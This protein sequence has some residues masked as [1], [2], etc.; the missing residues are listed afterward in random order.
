MAPN[1]NNL[2]L[3]RYKKSPK[4]LFKLFLVFL[5]VLAVLM[6]I[7]WVLTKINDSM[8]IEPANLNLFHCKVDYEELKN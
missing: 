4:C 1:N 6:K 8:P 2:D 5:A 3:L 7:N